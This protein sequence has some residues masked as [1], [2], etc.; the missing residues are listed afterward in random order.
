MCWTLLQNENKCRSARSNK[1][2][3][4]YTS[5]ADVCVSVPS[6]GIPLPV[7]S[8]CPLLLECAQS[9][10]WVSSSHPYPFR[11]SHPP[12]HRDGHVTEIRPSQT[13]LELSLRL[14]RK[15]S[16][17]LLSWLG[18]KPRAEKKP[19]DHWQRTEATWKRVE[20]GWKGWRMITWD[21]ELSKLGRPLQR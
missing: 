6:P 8:A 10:A 1:C 16:S 7:A 13:L 17:S 15:E 21:H 14:L 4:I 11:V 9:L 5:E 3:V 20:G 12:G 18:C 2:T 19:S